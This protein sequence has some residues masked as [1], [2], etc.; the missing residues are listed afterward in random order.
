MQFDITF[1]RHQDPK[2]YRATV[3][4]LLHA[5]NLLKMVVR[6]GGKELFMNKYLHRKGNQW[7]IITANF[8]FGS[9]S[10]RSAMMILDI[11]KAIDKVLETR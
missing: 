7:K 5:D 4:I 9:D 10:K 2:L 11:Q 8:N 6:A 3:E 1:R